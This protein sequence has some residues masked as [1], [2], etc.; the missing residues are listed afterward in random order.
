MWFFTLIIWVIN[1]DEQREFG[2]VG[3][4]HLHNRKDWICSASTGVLTRTYFLS[5]GYQSFTSLDYKVC[6]CKEWVQ[7]FPMLVNMV[8][9]SLGNSVTTQE[10]I[11]EQG[12]LIA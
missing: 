3:G 7:V 5:C 12:T 1:N 8:I 2:D 10:G 9:I 6:A 11:Q 4:L